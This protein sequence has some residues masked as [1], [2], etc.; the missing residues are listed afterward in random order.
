MICLNCDTEIDGG[1]FCPACRYLAKCGPISPRG[2]Q[3]ERLINRRW[4]MR[5]N[6]G[7]IVNELV[8]KVKSL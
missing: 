3:Y 2:N 7:E 4:Q 6:R 1:E 5:F 8:A